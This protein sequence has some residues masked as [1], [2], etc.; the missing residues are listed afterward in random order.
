[1]QV[2]CLLL[3]VFSLAPLFSGAIWYLELFTHFRLHYLVIA[4]VLAYGFLILK[5]KKFGLLAVMMVVINLVFVMP[6]YSK[7]PTE[8][9]GLNGKSIKLFHANVLT[10]NTQYQKLINQ[11]LAENPDVVLL[12]EVNKLWLSELDVLKEPYPYQIESPSPDNFGMALFS[13]IPI[14]HHAIHFWSDFKIPNIEAEFDLDGIAFRMITTHPLP[15]VNALYFN[16]RSSQFKS[17]AALIK[18]SELPSIVMGDLNTTIW[19]DSY[20]ALLSDTGL[21]NASDGFGFMP[22]WPT[23]LFPMMIPIDHCLVSEAFRVVDIRTGK[24]LGSDHLP[25]VVELGF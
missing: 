1:M 25:L 5:K 6:I 14:S 18:T 12:Q 7:Q 4:L 9:G 21:T 15:P 23:S 16:A 22:T 20:Q 11:V 8:S 13:K 10:S 3:L 17:I 19:S 24:D 2:G